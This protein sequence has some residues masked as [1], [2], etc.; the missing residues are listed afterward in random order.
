M[1]G[2]GF[3]NQQANPVGSWR[4]GYM[5]AQQTQ[6]N[7]HTGSDSNVQFPIG[8][9]Q[10][11]GVVANTGPQ[12]PGTRGG[13]PG[14][15]NTQGSYA[16][17][18]PNVS[19]EGEFTPKLPY[20]G[21]TGTNQLSQFGRPRVL[22]VGQESAWRGGLDFSNDKLIAFD[23]HPI[24]NVGYERSG[25]GSGQTDPPLDGPPRPALRLVQRT[26]NWQQGNPLAHQDHLPGE[27]RGYS[28]AQMA[29]PSRA[30][31]GTHFGPDGHRKIESGS[32]YVG[33]Q[34]IGWSPVY[35]GVPGM[36]QPY[37]SYAGVTNGPVQGIQS[38]AQQGGPG[39]GPQKVFS[40]PPHGL[41]SQTYPD[42]ASTLGRYMAIPQMSLPR[43]D[44]PA[45]STSGGQSYS[46]T[47]Q[48]QGQTGTATVQFNPQ[49]Q[50]GT[51]GMQSP[52]GAWRGQ[53][54]GTGNF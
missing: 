42:Y 13:V 19:T 16:Y 2:F 18:N 47:V 3:I 29:S 28:M 52:G 14:G 25:R 38:P 40:G 17:G 5:G 23:R 35:G 10:F 22:G 4:G 9:R 33:E 44:R 27:N 12:P 48:P 50:S 11:G 26:I 54:P 15:P 41:H 43:Q 39:D 6:T 37:G 46:Q 21:E 34:G 20:G 36:W 24:L 8:S 32:Q 51:G 7:Q 53:L 45:N 1:A 30:I 49:A 31:P